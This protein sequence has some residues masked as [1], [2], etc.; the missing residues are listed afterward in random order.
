MSGIQRLESVS[1]N[2]DEAAVYGAWER[3]VQGENDICGVRP[4][5]AISWHRCRDQYH[6]DPYLSEAPPAVAEVAHPLEHDVVFAELGFLA[7]AMIHEVSN[8][9]GIVTVAD[10]TGRIL[11]EWGDKATCSIAAGAGLAPW[12]CWSER[13]VGTNGMG[14]ALETQNP[15]VIRREEHWCQAFHDWTCVA[16]AVRDVV[17]KEPIAV[18]NISCWRS[19]LPASARGWLAN[20]AAHTQSRLRMR[21]RDGGAQLVAAYNQARGESTEPLAA[22]DTSGKVVVADDTASV[23]LGVPGNAPAVN[24]AVRWNPRLPAFVDA[25]RYA[26]KQASRNPDWIGSTQIFTHLVDDPTPIGICPVFQYGNL[27]GHLISFGVREGEPLPDAEV[28]AH[29]QGKP[30]R[31]VGVRESRMVLLRLPEVVLAESEGNEVWLSTDQ[32]RLRA[33]SSGL[34][35]LDNELSNAGFL[36]VHRRYVVNLS[37]V[38]EV[39]RQDKG[40]LVLIMDDDANTIVP[41]S[42][43]NARAVRR[44]LGI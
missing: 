31:V 42:R 10:A 9:G 33:S 12:F 25:A 2:R 38:R 27:V 16:A 32:G 15:V 41:V 6:V 35:K 34:D 43:R 19:E 23:L 30:R 17:S 1:R 39:E 26:S 13:A 36:R 21:A 5:V 11:A 40:E 8:F 18:L 29:P 28:G 20:A 24:P 3:F 37:R 4:E 7:A 14:T 22:V 44:V